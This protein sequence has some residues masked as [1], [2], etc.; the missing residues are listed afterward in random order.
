MTGDKTETPALP[1]PAECRRCGGEHAPRG[2]GS[3]VRALLR[4]SLLCRQRP[5][6]EVRGAPLLVSLKETPVRTASMDASG[7]SENQHWV[8]AASG[9]R[10]RCPGH[11]QRQHPPHL[12]HLL[13]CPGSLS[14]KK[15]PPLR[16]PAGRPHPRPAPTMPGARAQRHH[17]CPAAQDQPA[18][19]A[20]S[21]SRHVHQRRGGAAARLPGLGAPS[22]PT[23][24]YLLSLHHNAGCWQKATGHPTSGVT[25]RRRLCNVHCWKFNPNN[26]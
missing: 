19:R 13:T 25:E 10:R 20:S 5:G 24:G 3:P 15:H 21:T 1:S 23:Q 2:R 14:S 11:G 22:D 8:T 12:H 7:F 16:S 17:H 26:F 9:S 18:Q 4:S 6:P